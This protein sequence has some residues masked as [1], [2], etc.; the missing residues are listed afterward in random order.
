M[1]ETTLHSSVLAGFRYDP[2]SRQLW[3][4]FR[5]GDLY[6]YQMVPAAVMQ[7][8]LEAPSHGRYFNT[9]YSRTLPMLPLILALMGRSPGPTQPF[10]N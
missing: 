4:R 3:L 1:N 10:G 2:D 9:V 8:L 6:L 7:A 5:S